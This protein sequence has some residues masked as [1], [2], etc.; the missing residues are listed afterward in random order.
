M[1]SIWLSSDC[2]NI[3]LLIEL[4]LKIS[5]NKKFEAS[6][7]LKF[8]FCLSILREFLSNPFAIITSKNTLFNS[9]AK[10]L[11]ILKLHETIPPK[12]LTGSQD[13]AYL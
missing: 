7:S 5:L 3:E 6:I 9:N 1:E 11:V 8:F 2:S 13:K 12:A 10:F 4:N